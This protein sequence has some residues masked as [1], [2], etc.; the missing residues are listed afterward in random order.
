M[1]A[2]TRGE[3]SAVIPNYDEDDEKRGLL[4]KFFNGLPGKIFLTS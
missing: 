2:K 4:S 1:G 3:R